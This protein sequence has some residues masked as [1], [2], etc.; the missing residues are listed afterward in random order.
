MQEIRQLKSKLQKDKF[1]KKL[2]YSLSLFFTLH[3]AYY[4][5][6]LNDLRKRRPISQ[7]LGQKIYLLYLRKKKTKESGT[8]YEFCWVF[9]FSVKNLVSVDDNDF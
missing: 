8:D 5:K 3:V 2:L 6:I 9:L 7:K 4:S 1:V